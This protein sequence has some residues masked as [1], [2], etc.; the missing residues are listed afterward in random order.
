MEEERQPN[1]LCLI[2]TLILA[3]GTNKRLIHLLTERAN[4]LSHLYAQCF[5][6]AL[7]QIVIFVRLCACWVRLRHDL[8]GLFLFL[9]IITVIHAALEHFKIE[10]RSVFSIRQEVAAFPDDL[11]VRLLCF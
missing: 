10:G 11:I 5:C 1:L 9:R 8:L 7:D 6:G 3:K 4:L 2:F